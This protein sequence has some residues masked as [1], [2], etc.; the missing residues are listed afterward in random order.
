MQRAFRLIGD[1]QMRLIIHR[2]IR[3]FERENDI[4]ES[5][6]SDHGFVSKSTL[7]ESFRTRPPVFRQNV[8]FHRTGVDADANRNTAL[9][10]SPDYRP[11]VFLSADVARINAHFVGAIA[12]R[13]DRQSIIEMD[14]GHQRNPAV[15]PYLLQSVCR[16]LIG[17]GHSHDFTARFFKTPDLL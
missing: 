6:V 9:F 12:Y 14:I 7:R 2:S 13:L 3:R 10:R 5:H 1:Q 17:Y 15:F 4:V 16:L 8:F 11:D